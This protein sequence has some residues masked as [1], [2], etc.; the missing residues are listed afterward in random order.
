MTPKAAA[1]G[2]S[3]DGEARIRVTLTRDSVCMADDVHSPHEE[4]FLV[5]ADASL[6]DVVATVSRSSYLP[7]PSDAWGWSIAARGWVLA[8]RPGLFGRKVVTL[9]TGPATVAARDVPVLEAI[10]VQPGS[11][12]RLV[13]EAPP[14]AVPRHRATLRWLLLLALFVVIAGALSRTA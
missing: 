14:S 10:Y 2:T 6:A 7:M 11:R 1:T 5:P 4:G 12:W 3:V 9:K 13:D 8:V